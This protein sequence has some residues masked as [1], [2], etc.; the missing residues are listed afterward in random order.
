MVV[1]PNVAPSVEA[2]PTAPELLL[3]VLLYAVCVFDQHTAPE[4]SPAAPPVAVRDPEKVIFERVL[5]TGAMTA[6]AWE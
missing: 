1:V 6:Y 3:A 4:V 5:K 2:Q